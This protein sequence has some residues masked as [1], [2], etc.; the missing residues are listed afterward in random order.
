MRWVLGAGLRRPDEETYPADQR[1]ALA[2]DDTLS[3]IL[4]EE[5]LRTRVLNL[6][7]ASSRVMD[8]EEI[9][10]SLK[11]KD[12]QKVINSLKDLAQKGSCP[13]YSRTARPISS[14]A[15]GLFRRA[16]QRNAM[17]GAETDHSMT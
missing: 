11:E 17:E 14:C 9:S 13:E 3:D 16:N 10:D 7:K 8:L 5:F 4:S 2:F 6:L 1:N 15:E 12:R